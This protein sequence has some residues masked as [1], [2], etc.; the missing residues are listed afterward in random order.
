[1]E[2]VAVS[3]AS[4]AVVPPVGGATM[5]VLPSAVQDLAR[6]FLNLAGSSSLGAVGGVAGVAAPASGVGAQLC[7]T[8][9][10]GGAVA[11]CAA[12]AIPAGVVDPPAAPARPV[13]SSVRGSPALAGVAVTRPAMGPVKHRGSVLGVVLLPLV[14]LLATGRGPIGLLRNLPKMTEP[15]LLLPCLDVR[16]EVLL[17]ILAPLRRVTVRLVLALRAGGRGRPQ[18]RSGIAQVLAVVCPPRLRA[19]RMT[20]VVVPL[21]LWT[22]TGMTHSGPSWPSSGTSTAWKSWR[23][24]LQ[25]EARL[26]LH[27]SMG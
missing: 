2:A 16:L 12:T 3:G 19:R 26:L 22:S 9:P 21:M 25:L 7:P 5:A 27:R 14:V 13:F 20:T 15:R 4:A 17:A 23:V 1:M 10:G 8:A 18:E 11:P 24:F 6:F